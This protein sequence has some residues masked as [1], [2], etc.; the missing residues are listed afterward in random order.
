MTQH[1]EKTKCKYF[2]CKIYTVP[3]IRATSHR[4]WFFIKFNQFFYIFALTVPMSLPWIVV[5]RSQRT[6][7]GLFCV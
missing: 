3:Y 4:H 6:I 5:T 7:L 1:L 2:S